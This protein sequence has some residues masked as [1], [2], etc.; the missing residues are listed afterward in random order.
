MKQLLCLILATLIFGMTACNVT[1]GSTLPGDTPNTPD[2]SVPTPPD[3][4]NPSIGDNDFDVVIGGGTGETNPSKDNPPEDNPPVDNPPVDNPPVDNPPV[5]NPPEDNPPADNPPKDN[6]P[7]DNPPVDNPPVDNPPVDNPPEDNPPEDNPPVENPPVDNPPVVN[8]P[9]VDPSLGDVPASSQVANGFVVKQK[10]YDHGSNNLI[11]LN[12]TN[13]N[14]ENYIV[15]ITGYYLDT[16][17]NVLKTETQTVNGYVANYE[18]YFSF[19][20]EI[21]FDKFVFTLTA[22]KYSGECLDQ[23]FSLK[24]PWIGIRSASDPWGGK[25]HNLNIYA[26][27]WGRLDAKYDAKT[28]IIIIGSN[29]TVYDILLSYIGNLTNVDIRPGQIWHLKSSTVSADDAWI[30]ELKN[31]YTIIVTHTIV[32][33]GER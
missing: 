22:E 6:P 25:E 32:L 11:V 20:P 16:N 23:L 3:E 21:A 30:P 31:G 5:D 7:V 17:G 18:K 26:D 2:V 28:K 13:N 24:N 10:K 19:I 8:P 14:S 12:V 15:T 27:I 33:D 1:Q 4:F 9:V 29:G